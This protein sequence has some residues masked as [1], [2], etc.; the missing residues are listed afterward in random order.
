VLLTAIRGPDGLAKYHPVKKVLR[1]FRR[2]IL[3][4]AMD[5]KIINHPGTEGGGSFTGTSINIGEV[6]DWEEYMDQRIDQY[7]IE[8][9]E[10][11]MHFHMHLMHAVQIVGYH[12]PDERIRKWWHG[13]Y[14]RFV[15]A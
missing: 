2:C 9:D 14:I 13:V 12:H 7:M 4:S 5:K 6:D 3:L 10:V 1:W 15:Q 11:P 8:L